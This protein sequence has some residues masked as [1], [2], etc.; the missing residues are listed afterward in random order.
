[1]K[2]DACDKVPCLHLHCR[3]DRGRRDRCLGCTEFS[4]T[5]SYSYRLTIAVE[6]DGLVHTGSSVIEV[7]YRF[8]P[9]WAAAIANGSRYS[10]RITGQAVVVDLTTRGSL[11]AALHAGTGS[12]HVGIAAD[13]LA[14]RAFGVLPTPGAVRHI[15][16]QQGSVELTPDNLPP[17]IWFPSLTA[18]DNAQTVNPANMAGVIGDSARFVS[19]TVEI[20][21]DPIVI[22]FDKRAPWY[23][24]LKATNGQ[25][26]VGAT[27]TGAGRSPAGAAGGILLGYT[28]FVGLGRTP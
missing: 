15:S 17:F 12:G 6:V 23:D 25:L 7:S 20:T 26:R 10:V 19:A 22:D 28:A 2:S 13:S 4:A 9:E 3:F 16:R 18:P 5:A 1:V 8:N 21:H 11:V 14:G 27:A 24:A